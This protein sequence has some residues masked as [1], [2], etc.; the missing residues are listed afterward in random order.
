MDTC[1]N[2]NEPWKHYVKWKPDT[3]ND[4]LYDSIYTKYTE[5]ENPQRQKVD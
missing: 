1:F 3:K 5:E 4:L 2:M